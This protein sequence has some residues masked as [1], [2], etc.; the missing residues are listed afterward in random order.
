MGLRDNQGDGRCRGDKIMPSLFVVGKRSFS[1]WLSLGLIFAD[2][3]N[4]IELCY[5]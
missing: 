2:A 5:A 4:I 1:G 3:D